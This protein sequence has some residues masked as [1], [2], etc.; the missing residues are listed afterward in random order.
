MK[1]FMKIGFFTLAVVL[2]SVGAAMACNPLEN[3]NEEV[4]VVPEMQLTLSHAVRDP[5]CPGRYPQT[6]FPLTRFGTDGNLLTNIPAVAPGRDIL[7]V[8]IFLS[9]S[10]GIGALGIFSN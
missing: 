2:L 1:T 7:S 5:C 9:L 3:C 6:D 8:F 4:V 10:C